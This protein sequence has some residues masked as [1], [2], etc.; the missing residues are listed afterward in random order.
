MNGEF[1]IIWLSRLKVA[2]DELYGQI[3]GMGVMVLNFTKKKK[4][5]YKQ[6]FEHRMHVTSS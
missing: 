6:I 3:T 4:T 5:S 2:Y 1:A